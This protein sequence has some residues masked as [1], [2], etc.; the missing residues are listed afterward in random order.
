MADDEQPISKSQLKR[1]AQATRSLG[2]DLLA[3][4]ESQL[5]R[6]PMDTTLAEA[7]QQARKINSHGARRRQLQYIAKLIR[8][9]DADPIINAV[10]AIHDEARGLKAQQHRIEAWR[11]YLV[12]SGDAAL[13]YLLRHNAQL[14]TQEMRQLMRNAQREQSA[15]KPPTAARALFRL[16]RDLDSAQPLPP[17]P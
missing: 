13:E 14:N 16:L 4:S 1:E 10:T 9:G 17:C 15:G 8:R 7:I 2:A 12:D 5:R 3:L 6:V 11:Q